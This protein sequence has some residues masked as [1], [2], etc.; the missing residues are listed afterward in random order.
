M[1]AMTAPSLVKTVMLRRPYSIAPPVRELWL[2]GDDLNHVTPCYSPLTFFFQNGEVP[3]LCI[4]EI[5]TA[6]IYFLYSKKTGK[7]PYI[8]ATKQRCKSTTKLV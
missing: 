8:E 1:I 5:H 2:A 6:S 3:G 4:E 7:K